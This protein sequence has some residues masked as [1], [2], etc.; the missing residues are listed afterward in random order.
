MVF[1]RI[2]D[3]PNL[4]SI[5]FYF[6][7]SIAFIRASDGPLVFAPFPVCSQRFSSG[8]FSVHFGYAYGTISMEKKVKEEFSRHF[9]QK[10]SSL[11]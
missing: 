7:F 4:P 1:C 10:F 6:P 11:G 9:F 2:D 3:V 5:I 8:T